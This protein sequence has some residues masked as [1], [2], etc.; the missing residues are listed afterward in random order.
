M[1]GQPPHLSTRR[2]PTV[3]PIR[4]AINWTLPFSACT[5]PSCSR[6]MPRIS[7]TDAVGTR[8]PAPAPEMVLPVTSC[9]TESLS[10]HITEPMRNMVIEAMKV[11]RGPRRSMTQAEAVIVAHS[12]S[13]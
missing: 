9:H 5:L 13:R 7:R 11:S 8:I 4:G 10:A 1:A 3:G 6:G 2:P 12:A